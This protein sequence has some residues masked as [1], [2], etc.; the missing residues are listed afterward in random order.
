MD[1]NPSEEQAL[2]RDS[3]AGFLRDAPASVQD[4]WDGMAGLGWL[5]I[6]LPEEAGGIGGAVEAAIVAE[7][8]GRSL[9]PAPFLSSTV[10]GGHLVAAAG[11]DEQRARLLPALL[12]GRLRLAVAWAEPGDRLLPDGA[13]TA[14]SRQGAGYRITGR[15]DLVPD[16]A[17]AGLLVV[18]ARLPDGGTG[19]FLL[20]PDMP[21]LALRAGRLLDGRG[22]ADL[23]LE[24]VET[25][26]ETLLGG[27][28]AP[29]A[30]LEDTFDRA[31]AA[32]CADA[33]GAM[34]EAVRTTAEYLKTRRQFGTALSTF[35]ALRHRIAD[36]HMEAEH[37]ASLALAA[38]MAC[39]AGD[40][41]SRTRLVSAAK[42]R[43][44]KAGRFVG[45]AAIQLHGGI[46]MTEE[47]AIGRFHKRLLVA[48]ALLGSRAWHLDRLAANPPA[49]NEAAT[50]AQDAA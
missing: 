50:P 2:L 21:G 5:G 36:M 28:A 13:E 44:G 34:R 29:A 24:E 26:P 33:V 8:L 23:V 17:D 42:A 4:A 37:A 27:G 32:L 19:L 16:A 12:E 45:E 49:G 25:G 9:S 1:F 3:V 31:T 10:F 20:P 11:T 30:V 48:D 47:H 6:S 39:D 35:Q 41:L 46:G 38:A 15:K 40:P 43:T 18:P 14:A 7:G 22:F